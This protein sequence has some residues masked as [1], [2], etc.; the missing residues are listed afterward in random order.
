MAVDIRDSYDAVAEDYRDAVAD[1]LAFKAF[2]RAM[3][4]AF[5]ELVADSGGGLVADI[6]CSPGH[7][8]AR[9]VE[10]GMD[11]FGIDLS[12]G[13]VAVAVAV[14]VARADHPTLRFDVGTMTT[15]ALDHEGLAGIVARYSTIHRSDDDLAVAFGEFHR[16]LQPHGHVLLDFQVGDETLVRT[17]AY[18]HKVA[19][20]TYRRPVDVVIATLEAAGFAIVAELV[21]APDSREKVRQCHLIARGSATDNG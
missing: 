6:G 3:L 18:G 10:L 16:A 5:A 13:M 19:L 12:P 1:D 8:T 17:E 15:L 2:D 7:T 11:A 4:S 14:A 9:P 20:V 21:R